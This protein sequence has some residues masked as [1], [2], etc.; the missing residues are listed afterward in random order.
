[1]W[2]LSNSLL[3]LSGGSKEGEWVWWQLGLGEEVRREQNL[4]FYTPSILKYKMFYL[5]E[6]NIARHLLVCRFS[7][8]YTLKDV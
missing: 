6:T 7:R 3:W 4:L 1:V 5:C 2:A 8:I